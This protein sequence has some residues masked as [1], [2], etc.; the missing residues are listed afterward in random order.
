LVLKQLLQFPVLFFD[1]LVLHG[2]FH[3]RVDATSLHRILFAAPF[4]LFQGLLQQRGFIDEFALVVERI[5]EVL[6]AHF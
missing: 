3:E 6:V 5:N 2:F 4:V 1:F